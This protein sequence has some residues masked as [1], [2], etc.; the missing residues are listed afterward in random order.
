MGGVMLEW[1]PEKIL[2]DFYSDADLRTA[3]RQALFVHAD[4]RLFNRGELSEQ[5]LVQRVAGRSRRPADELCALLDSMRE[6]LQTK[7]ATVNLLRSLQRR[8]IPL[9]CLSDM[10]VT[11]YRYLRQRHDF[12][13]AF[14]GIVISAEVRL[15]KPEPA[16][17]EHLLTRYRLNPAETVFIDDL[18]ANVDSARA[19]GMQAI[20]FRDIGQVER[21]LLPLLAASSA[22]SSN[23]S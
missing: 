1:N 20:Q 17:F 23:S 12:W 6:S 9:Y 5:D 14:S 19:S 15:L 10:P 3:L 21:E 8:G 4:W 16:I 7:P 18:A 22:S 11:V 13:D 2:V